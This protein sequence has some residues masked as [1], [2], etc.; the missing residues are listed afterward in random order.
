MKVDVQAQTVK[1]MQEICAFLNAECGHLYLGV[2]DI[3]YEMGLEED[4]K[5]PLFKGS[6]DKFEVY[7]N[8][9]IV[10]YLGQEGAHYVHTHFDNEVNNVVL[11]IDIEPCPHPIAV[12]SEYF[13]RMGTSARKVNENYKD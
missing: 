8:N 5:N 1:I 7:V 6:N 10:Y 3:G 13:E 4:L 2:S 11:I 9:Q 12:S